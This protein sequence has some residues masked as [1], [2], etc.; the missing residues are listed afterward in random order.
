MKKHV[1]RKCAP[2]L[3][4]TPEQRYHIV[5]DAAYFRA[6]KHQQETG[7]GDDQAE[8]WCEVEAEI[9]EVLKRHHVK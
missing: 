5:N 2:P 3:E 7:K 1:T 9:T 4:V 6:M 8:S